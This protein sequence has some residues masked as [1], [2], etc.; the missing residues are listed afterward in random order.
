MLPL[1]VSVHIYDYLQGTR[2]KFIM[3]LFCCG[4]ATQRGSWPS[5]S[6]AFLDH[7]QRRTTV[8][9]TSLDEWSA[10]R[11][12]IYLTTHNT[13]NKH[14]CPRW[15][16]NPR[17]QQDFMQLLSWIPLM[18]VRCVFV[19]YAAVCHYRLFVCVS[20][21]TLRVRSRT[22]QKHNEPTSTELNLVTA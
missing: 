22:V 20:G 12:D 8:G 21:A 14:P 11:S 5:H 19:S 3:Q 4:A 6:W 13:H 16:S 7:T 2:K 10:R 1:H 18:Y 9:R 15:D 17:S